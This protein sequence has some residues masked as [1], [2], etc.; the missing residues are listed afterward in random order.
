MGNKDR[1]RRWASLTIR[2]TQSKGTMRCLSPHTRQET[3]TR[4]ARMRRNQ[5]PHSHRA[6]PRGGASKSQNGIATRAATHCTAGYGPS[7]HA[8]DGELHG[9]GVEAAG[10]SSGTRMGD[11]TRWMHTAERHSACG[12]AR[13][14]GTLRGQNQPVTET[15]MPGGS[16]PPPPDGTPRGVTFSETD[17]GKANAGGR[18]RGE[19]PSAPDG[20]RAAAW[21]DG[22]RSRDGRTDGGLY[23]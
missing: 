14:A 23:T 16:P 12:A 17:G 6:K 4:A 15:Q 19:R 9:M 11:E 21:Q 5:N 3:R 8:R 20:D 7:K 2:E 13:S 18:G 22:E 1:K 10:G